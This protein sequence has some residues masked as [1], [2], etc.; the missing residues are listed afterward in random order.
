MAKIIPQAEKMLK[1]CIER[2]IV[3]FYRGNGELASKERASSLE[4]LKKQLALAYKMNAQ[5][6]KLIEIYMDSYARGVVQGAAFIHQVVRTQILR[7]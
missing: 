1:E 4:M 3:E 6:L 5:E 2:E 7:G